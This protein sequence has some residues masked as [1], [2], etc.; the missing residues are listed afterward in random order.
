MK[1]FTIFFLFGLFVSCKPTNDKTILEEIASAYGYEHWQNVEEIEFTFRVKKP[2]FD[3]RTWVWNTSSQEIRYMASGDTLQFSSSQALDE[4]YLSIDKMFINDKYWLLTP[5]Q[6]IWDQQSFTYTQP[7][8]A[9]A[10]I[11][12]IQMN[13]FT[14][15]YNHD[16]GYTP[17]DAYDFYYTNEFTIKEWTFRRAN[18]KEPSL[19]TTWENERIVNDIVIPTLYKGENE[20][21]LFFEKIT[22]K[23]KQARKQ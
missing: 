23:K 11:S 15:V 14:I 7:E 8:Q 12:G 22:I 19:T 2:G 4:P 3:G 5:F 17:G 20:F 18:Q 21:A 10:P 1:E 6:L 16:D 9:I 13:K